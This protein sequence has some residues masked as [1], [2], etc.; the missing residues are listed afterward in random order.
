MTS[1]PAQPESATSVELVRSVSFGSRVAEDA[2]DDLS[3]YFVKTE[4]WR[5]VRGGEVDVVLA[6]K[7]SGKSALYSMLIADEDAL[8]DDK[9]LLVPAENPTDTPAFATVGTDDPSE[10]D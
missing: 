1:Q 4:T 8:F 10:D 7:G 9:V 5:Q 6:P 2:V 3:S